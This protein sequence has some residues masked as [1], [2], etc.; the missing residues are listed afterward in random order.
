MTPRYLLDT[1]ICIYIINRRPPEVFRHFDGVA[2]GQIGISS[3][4]HAELDFGVAKS[5][6]RRN[7]AALDKFLLPLEIM[8]FDADAARQYGRLRA[9]LERLGTP[10]GAL[11][12]LIAAHALALGVTLVSNN[13]R[14]F[15][16]VPKLRLENWAGAP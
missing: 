2:A 4:T 10:I 16:R 9:R 7:R 12:T 1:N 13:T 15:E 8:P 14:E 11:D 3:I 5:G 6:S